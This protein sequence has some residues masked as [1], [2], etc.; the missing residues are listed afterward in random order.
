MKLSRP[1][2]LL[3]IDN[4]ES[5][6]P[7]QIRALDFVK[8]TGHINHPNGTVN[9]GFNGKVIVN[10]FDKRVNKSTLNN[11]GNLTPILHYTEEGSPIVKA[12]G[13]AV[14]GQ[15]TVE[16]YVP[17]D[18]NYTLGTG[19]II[20]YADNNVEDVFQNQPY[21]IGDINPN[22]INDNEPP[23][24]KLYMNNTN[25]A[26][27]GITDQNPMLLACVT[28]DTGINSTGAGIGHD[29]ITYLDGQI[30][31]TTVLNDFYNPGDGN[32]CLNPTLAEYQKGSVTYPFRN[33][34]P[35]E[36]TLTFRVWDINNNSTTE[37]LRFIV[38][39]EASQNLVINRPLNWPNPFTDKTY[40]HFEHN[41]D[42]ILD[43]NVQIFTITGKLVKTISQT[44]MAEPFL[45]G[46]RTP[47]HSI[48]WDGKDDFG[49]AV[50]KGTYIFKIFA[51]SQNQEKCKGGA[52]AIEKMVLLR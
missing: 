17:N 9:T 20:A 50:G 37:T 51:R 47:R 14:N 34:A 7:G 40:I 10:I 3:F 32:G 36:H 29:I 16:F 19:R 5:P 35:G 43:V 23:R 41:C 52:T 22:G 21:Q 8:I 24:V 45:Q 42:D 46:F 25:F 49:D 31:N 48:G 13:T 30:I 12:S 39:D 6:V 33:L 27:G 26:D 4:I 2:K 38:K 1:K 18:I 15:F 44:V 11:D 28:D